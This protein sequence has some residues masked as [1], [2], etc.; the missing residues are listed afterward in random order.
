MRL[1][2]ARLP[3]VTLRTELCADEARGKYYV[4]LHPPRLGGRALARVVGVCWQHASI[5]QNGNN[6]GAETFQRGRDNDSQIVPFGNGNGAGVH[7][8]GR[9]NNAGIGQNGDGNY[10][11]VWQ[12]RH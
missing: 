9:N 2:N 8:V 6:N 7:Q 3:C 10:A 1:Q 11:G 12:R 4:S 5:V